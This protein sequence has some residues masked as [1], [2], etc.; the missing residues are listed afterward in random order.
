MSL[1]VNGLNLPIKRYRLTEWIR[2]E[3]PSFCCLQETHLNFKERRYLRVKGW[4]KIF[5]SNGLKK[6]A[7]VAILI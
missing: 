6:Q 3:Y 7:G 1:N 5:Q 4:E 2:R